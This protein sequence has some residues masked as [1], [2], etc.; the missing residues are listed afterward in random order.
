MLPTQQLQIKKAYFD[1]I[2]QKTFPCIGAKAAMARSQAHCMVAGNMACP[3]DDAGILNFLY[4][5]TDR[6]R[7]ADNLFHSAAIIFE[8]PEEMSE[9][10]FERLLW[11]RLQSISN[12]DAANFPY[13]S[14][15]SA[16]TDSAD[17][18]FSLKE[19][20]YFILGMHPFSSRPSRR[21][22]Y[23]TLIFNPHAQFEEMKKNNKYEMMKQAVRKRDLIFSGSVNPM[24]NDHGNSP[25]TYQYSGKNYFPPLQCPLKINHANK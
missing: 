23:P 19:E 3:A 21:F 6:Y 1:F 10:I 24:L 2:N 14:R 22:A 7:N 13:D 4:E 12:L 11:Q 25:E 9:A 8:G 16:N 20:A 15:V 5:F 17:F 18:S